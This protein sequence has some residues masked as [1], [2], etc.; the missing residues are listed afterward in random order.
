MRMKILL[1]LLLLG[2]VFASLT[3]GTLSSYTAASSFGVS[4]GPDSGKLRQQAEYE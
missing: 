1:I 2:A 3:V 4:I